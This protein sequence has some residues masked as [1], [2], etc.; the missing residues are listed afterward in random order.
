[1]VESPVSANGENV[2]RFVTV[3]D[4]KKMVTLNL[5]DVVRLHLNILKQ[6]VIAESKD[7]NVRDVGKSNV[8]SNCRHP[9]T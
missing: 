2:K 3:Q 4:I 9:L 6:F 8:D 1:M 7:V 5:N